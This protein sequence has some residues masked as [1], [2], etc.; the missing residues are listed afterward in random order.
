MKKKIIIIITIILIICVLGVGDYFIIKNNSKIKK[1]NLNIISSI[2][3]NQILKAEIEKMKEAGI[4][5]EFYND[6][7][8]TWNNVFN[9][10]KLNE[11]IKYTDN[12]Y[13]PNSSSNKEQLENENV[14]IIENINNNVVEEKVIRII[15]YTTEGDPIIKTLKY[16][17]D[18]TSIENWFKNSKLIVIHDSSRDKYSVEDVIT[19][20]YSL[21][22]YKIGKKYVKKEDGEEWIDI[23]LGKRLI[24]QNT[25]TAGLPYI[26]SYKLSATGYKKDFEINFVGRKDLGVKK[27]IDKDISDKYDYN[28]YTIGGDITITIDGD[29]LYSFTDALNSNDILIDKILKQADI[30]ADAGVCYYGYYKDGGSKIY[31]YTDY[32]IIKFN[33]LDG[34]KDFVIYPYLSNLSID[35]IKKII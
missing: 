20:E 24:L 31:E 9:F 19:K 30:D 6:V 11:F 18:T 34:K 2:E 12:Y 3:D 26:C 23:L 13:I 1:E 29:M 15:E 17:P 16:V 4:K 14:T 28:V 8:I 27:I 7:V 22:E 10:N 25:D 32:T 35:D 5:E 21:Y 33:N